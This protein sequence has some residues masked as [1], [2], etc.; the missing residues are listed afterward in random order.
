[1]PAPDPLPPLLRLRPGTPV[2]RRG[3]EDVQVGLE[4]GGG[5]VLRGPGA[6]LLL[7]GLDGWHDRAA[8]RRLGGAAGLSP[9][10][11]DAVLATLQRAGL[12]DGTDHRP[13]ARAAQVRLV[14]DGVL[15]RQL[16]GL[17]LDAGVDLH[18]AG[19]DRPLD[20]ET[21]PSGAGPADL[22]PAG[23]GR[24]TVVRHWSKPE[25]DDLALTV[26]AVD[27]AEADRLVSDHLLRAD[28]P[29]LVLRSTGTAVTVGPL[30]LPGRSACLRCTDLGRRDL[31]PSWPRLLPQLVRLRQPVGAV[32][33]AWAASVAA[34]QALA[35]LHGGVPESVGATLELSS[36]DHLMRR[37]TWPLHP[38]CGCAWWGTTEWAP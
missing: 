30:V 7:Q 28:Q 17:L 36:A 2:L 35:F 6:R 19:L 22:R 20:P 11:V 24:W 9:D 12:L 4:P 13:P 33:T 14:G 15:A 25:R 10:G 31:D 38:G 26:L 29:H 3:S 8:L 37:R 16:T 34:A 1:M 21:L 32:L 27:T 23:Q 18:L 5:V